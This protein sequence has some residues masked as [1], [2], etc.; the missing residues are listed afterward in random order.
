MACSV[1]VTSAPRSPAR[2]WARARSSR[3]STLGPRR[4]ACSSARDGRLAVHQAQAQAPDALPGVGV[5]RAARRGAVGRLGG[6]VDR[7]HVLVDARREAM[8]RRALALDARPVAHGA[9]RGGEVAGLPEGQRHQAQDGGVA[10]LGVARVDQ[11]LGRQRVVALGHRVLGGG[12]EALHA[13]GARVGLGEVDELQR[14]GRHRPHAGRELDARP[15]LDVVAVAGEVDARDRADAPLRVAQAARVAVDDRV[16]GD[17]RAERV[18]LGL[19]G[20]VLAG[21]LL[22]LVGA[23]ALLGARFA[24]GRGARP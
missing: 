9:A 13:L 17:A 10:R 21:A 2:W 5:L 22:G 16:V 4:R 18:V 24:G 6:Q 12:H 23:A 3:P 20:G 7:A 19:V 15:L 8:R 14:A 11:A 1:A